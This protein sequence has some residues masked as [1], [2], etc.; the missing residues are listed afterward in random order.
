MSDHTPDGVD[1]VLIRTVVEATSVEPKVKAATWGASASALL[2]P[3]VLWALGVYLFDGEVP[4]PLQSLIG[5]A[6]SG[7]CTFVAGYYA[8][9]VDR[10]A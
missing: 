6:V 9:H 1:D 5:V 7:L 10:G 4:L 3:A 8:R 2:L